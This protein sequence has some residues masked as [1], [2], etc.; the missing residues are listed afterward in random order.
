MSYCRYVGL[1][2]ARVHFVAISGGG[3]REAMRKIGPNI[4]KNHASILSCFHY[5]CCHYLGFVLSLC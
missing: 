2:L 3:D 4:D 1:L 5:I